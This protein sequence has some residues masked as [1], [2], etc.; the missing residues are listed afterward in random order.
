[1]SRT[2][3]LKIFKNEQLI[4]SRTFSQ[5]VI[6]I[7]KL[8]SSD[9]YL[10]DDAVARMH[11]V[12]EVTAGELRL[13]DLGSASG[14]VV[15]GLRVVKSS[16]IKDGDA[17]CVGPFRLEVATHVA[18]MPASA[19]AAQPM[20]S[21]AAAA[22]ALAVAPA[23][24][25]APAPASPRATL[26]VDVRDVEHDDRHVAEVVTS[27]GS[28]ILDVQHVGQV[29][30]RRSQ[31]PAFFALGGLMLLAGA[32][33]LAHEVAQDWDGYQEARE[34]AAATGRP[35]PQ[36][37]GT[38]LGGLAIGLALLGLVPMGLGMTRRDDVGVDRYTLG[39]GPDASFL[40]QASD[41]PGG[42]APG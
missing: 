35:A 42:E 38:G 34:Q 9:L 17:L 15:N 29:R 40:V 23:F 21:Y 22:P 6:K 11:A 14:T 16:A 30:S 8:R 10:D 33:L 1:M 41:L 24:A 12:L 13:V 7:G 4:D 18:A 19:P 3:D 31:A 5:E 39:E 37:P 28:T 27:Y 26:P 32:G 20:A 36:E 2:I 25:P